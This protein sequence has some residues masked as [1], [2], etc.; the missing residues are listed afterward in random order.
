[1]ALFL[2]LSAPIGVQA[3][4]YAVG[5]T[6][7]WETGTNFLR[8]SQNYNFIVGDVLGDT[9]ISILIDIFCCLIIDFFCFSV[10]LCA[11]AAQR[12][13]GDGRDVQIL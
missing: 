3:T 4:E 12:V 10:Q 8:W 1:M 9:A 11:G 7:G 13:S 5:D 2:S 6:D